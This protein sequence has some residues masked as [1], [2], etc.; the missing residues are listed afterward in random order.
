MR[1]YSDE[2]EGFIASDIEI[3]NKY[4]LKLAAI[5]NKTHPSTHHTHIRYRYADHF[6]K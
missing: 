4:T 2:E 1:E 6:I 5:D 3:R